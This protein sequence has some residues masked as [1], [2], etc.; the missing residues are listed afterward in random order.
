MTHR[1]DV[2]PPN[3]E[4]AKGFEQIFTGM[5]Q[6]MSGFFNTWKPFMF[7]SPFPEVDSLYQLADTGTEYVL[8]YKEDTTDVTTTMSKQL[9]IREMKIISPTFKSVLKPQFTESPHGLLLAGYDATY[10]EP[11][12]TS[13]TT[14]NVR[15]DYRLAFGQQL[16]GKLT[17]AGTYEG[18]SFNMELA[19]RDYTVKNRLAPVAAPPETTPKKP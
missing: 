8:T 17:L 6:A 1:A 2:A 19:F 16:P 14:L 12:G 13:A 11:A 3:P 7:T 4:S 15:I 5:E 9:V 10:S 18:S